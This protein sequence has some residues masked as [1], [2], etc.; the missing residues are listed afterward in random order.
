MTL[1]GFFDLTGR[2]TTI[3]REVRGGI[4]T[5]VAKVDW[6]DLEIAIPAFLTIVVM[7]FSY[8]ITNGV[9]AGVITYTLI[10]TAHG[11]A[12]EAGWLLWIISAVFVVYFGLSIVGEVLGVK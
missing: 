11:R 8:S 9:G 10:K 3:A 12:K 7:P 1:D 5:F 6:S 4:T 2:Q